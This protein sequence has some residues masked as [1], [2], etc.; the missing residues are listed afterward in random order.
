MSMWGG[1]CSTGHWRH[2]LNEDD[3]EAMVDGIVSKSRKGDV[4]INVW[5]ELESNLTSRICLAA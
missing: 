3:A 4:E 2:V 1:A 5:D